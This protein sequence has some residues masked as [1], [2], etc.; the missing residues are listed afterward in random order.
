MGNLR[1]LSRATVML[2]QE[3]GSRPTPKGMPARRYRCRRPILAA[4]PRCFVWNIAPLAPMHRGRA[5]SLP[6]VHLIFGHG[7]EQ[8]E[9]RADAS[10]GNVRAAGKWKRG[11]AG[12]RVRDGVVEDGAAVGVEL[13]VQQ[14]GDEV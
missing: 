3:D 11:A 5:Q 14:G 8:V 10:G 7:H 9:H 2:P 4:I 1:V 12:W 13:V 6:S